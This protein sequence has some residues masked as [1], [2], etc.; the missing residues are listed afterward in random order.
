[1]KKLFLS[2]LIAVFCMAVFAI[3]KDTPSPEAPF[4]FPLPQ[5][6]N[7]IYDAFTRNYTS[8]TAAGSGYTGISKPG[9]LQQVLLNPAANMID[10]GSL[11]VDM[12]IKPPVDE[13]NRQGNALY[14]SPIPFGMLA[15]GTKLSE[16][17]NAALVYS[18][19][20]SVVQDDFSV[21]LGQGASLLQRYPTYYLHQVTASAAYHQGN[22]HAGLSVHNQIHYFDDI[23]FYRTFDRVNKYVYIARPEL[24]V[25]YANKSLSLGFT[26]IPEQEIEIN[27]PYASYSSVLPLKLGGGFTYVYENRSFSIEAEFEQ[28]SKITEEYDDR[29]TLHAGYEQRIGL[30]TYRLGFISHPEVFAGE[31]LYPA[32]E[33]DDEEIIFAWQDVAPGGKIG[34][35]GQHL[36]TAGVTLHHKDGT[37]NMSIMQD[38]A[39]RYPITQINLSL[40]LYLS[41]FKGKDI[42]KKS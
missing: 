16:S 1:M 13:L 42:S 11:Y 18:V 22:L 19:P 6:M 41:S 36:I 4:E 24:G 23:I 40:G 34:R 20:K 26:A 3:V 29:I 12:S 14:S 30:F 8:A 7:P 35:N 25:L 2:V 28:C 10:E 39:G 31:Y 5:F 15:I 27:T 33:T 32:F 37:V 21:I 17:V 38:A 9:G